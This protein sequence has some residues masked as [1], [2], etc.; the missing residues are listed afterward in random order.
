M[1]GKGGI[2]M[3]QLTCCRHIQAYPA[4]PAVCHAHPRKAWSLFCS[5]HPTCASTHPNQAH[6]VLC[7]EQGRLP[8]QQLLSESH[9]L[10]LGSHKLWGV[11]VGRATTSCEGRQGEGSHK[12]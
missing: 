5:T 9:D 1:G 10:V 6:L 4:R 2:T 3:P 11:A 8:G 12:L 7:L